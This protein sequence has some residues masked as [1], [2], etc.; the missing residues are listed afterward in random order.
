[1]ND[2]I[3]ANGI[4]K[5]STNPIGQ[6]TVR[7][8]LTHYLFGIGLPS[9]RLE[10]AMKK[11]LITILFLAPAFAWGKPHPED[12]PIAVHVQSSRLVMECH[13]VLAMGRT[14]CNQSLYLNV[15]IGQKAFDFKAAG[16][17]Y[18]YVLRPGDYNAKTLTDD[19][20]KDNPPGAYEYRQRYEFLFPDGKTRKFSVVSESE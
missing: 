9:T 20:D 18:E 15:K 19:P 8:A 10:E 4:G 2:H 6:G 12:Y 7:K 3:T 16:D 14:L 11:V 5:E 17:D 13:S 1:M